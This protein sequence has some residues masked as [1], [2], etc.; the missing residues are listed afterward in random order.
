M[1]R[2]AHNN[3]RSVP[4]GMWTREH[5][6]L[7]AQKG[8]TCPCLPKKGP[9]LS[10]GHLAS[11]TQKVSTTVKL[12]IYRSEKDGEGE[13][14]SPQSPNY[15]LLPFPSHKAT[16]TPHE[17]TPIPTFAAHRNTTSSPYSPK[18]TFGVHQQRISSVSHEQYHHG[19]VP[20]S[21]E[22]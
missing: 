2:P 7:L 21:E 11:I 16:P 6:K 1:T 4:K 13:S 10:P 8:H 22:W 15:P 18:P 9:S 12:S 19:E 20:L 14:P 17:A 5:N 3:K